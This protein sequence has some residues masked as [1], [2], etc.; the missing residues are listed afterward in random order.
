MTAYE[1]LSLI[2]ALF[3]SGKKSFT[4]LGEQSFSAQR[5]RNLVHILA[6]VPKPAIL[7]SFSL[8]FRIEIIVGRLL[9]SRLP[10]PLGLILAVGEIFKI[11]PKN[12][13]IFCVNPDFGPPKG[14]GSF[15][16]IFLKGFGEG[17][18]VECGLWG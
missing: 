12:F 13:R 18:G 5:F 10:L 14:V 15:F 8:L 3:R 17:V 6:S 2:S 1:R 4:D 7:F 16:C 9:P 11:F